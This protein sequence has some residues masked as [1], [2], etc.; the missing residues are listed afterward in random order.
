MGSMHGRLG[1]HRLSVLAIGLV[2]IGMFLSGITDVQTP[3]QKT[4]TTR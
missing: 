2:T 1:L 4:V 3:D